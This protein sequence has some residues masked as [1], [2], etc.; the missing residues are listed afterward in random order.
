MEVEEDGSERSRVIDP[1]DEDHGDL[2][3][4]VDTHK[5][6]PSDSVVVNLSNLW[7]VFKQELEK[8]RTAIFATFDKKLEENNEEFAKR[9]KGH[10]DLFKEEL[11]VQDKPVF[12]SKSNEK[13]FTRT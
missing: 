6:V 4:P 5:E 13:H 10:L 11:S 8:E 7:D 2:Q 3:D 12:K 9:V 1:T